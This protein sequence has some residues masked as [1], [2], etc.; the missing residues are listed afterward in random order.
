MKVQEL[1]KLYRQDGLIQ[2]LTEKVKNKSASGHYRIKGLHG[3]LDS[4]IASSIAQEVEGSHL[5]IVHDK[6]EAFLFFE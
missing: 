1:L 6:E 2:T 4:I 3:S 5:I